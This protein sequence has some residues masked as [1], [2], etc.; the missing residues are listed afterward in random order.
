MPCRLWTPHL[1]C[2]GPTYTASAWHA[3]LCCLAAQFSEA[4]TLYC[5]KMSGML[6]DTPCMMLL[7]LR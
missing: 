1:Q 7:L 5:S 3:C 6:L 2:D 4:L